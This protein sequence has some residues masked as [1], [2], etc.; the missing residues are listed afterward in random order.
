[1]YRF[2]F[3]ELL[4]VVFEEKENLVQKERSGGGRRKEDMIQKIL[5]IIVMLN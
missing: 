1:M 5:R 4:K 2:L 3:R